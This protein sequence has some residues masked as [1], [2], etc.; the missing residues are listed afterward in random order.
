M[1]STSA[2][3]VTHAGNLCLGANPSGG[4]ASRALQASQEYSGA[5]TS[6]GSALC[7]ELWAGDGSALGSLKLSQHQTTSQPQQGKLNKQLNVLWSCFWQ[8]LKMQI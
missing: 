8:E 6:L 3:D 2:L 4:N 5:A 7:L 1:G